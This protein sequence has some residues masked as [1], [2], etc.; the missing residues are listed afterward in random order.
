MTLTSGVYLT[1][2]LGPNLGSYFP[3]EIIAASTL[4]HVV[5]PL[6]LWG[7]YLSFS[8]LTLRWHHLGITALHPALYAAFTLTRGHLVDWYPYVFMDV[9]RLGLGPVIASLAVM[10]LVIPTAC[11][12]AHLLPY[13]QYRCGNHADTRELILARD[14]GPAHS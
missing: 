9:P 1:V 4:E 5:T 2:L 8:P 3:T 10:A 13:L 6:L 12:F 7:S 11:F 14:L